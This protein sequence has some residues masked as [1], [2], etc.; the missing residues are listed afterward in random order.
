MDK[1]GKYCD[2]NDEQK[3]SVN[4]PGIRAPPF[5]PTFD[6]PL[7]HLSSGTCADAVARLAGS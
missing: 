6:P 4:P 1:W 7:T 5:L 2:F 3:Q